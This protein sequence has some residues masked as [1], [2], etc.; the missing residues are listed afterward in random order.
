MQ[1]VPPAFSKPKSRGATINAPTV[2]DLT[3]LPSEGGASA[4]RI[5]IVTGEIAG[6][7]YNGGIGTANRG[8]ALSLQSAGFAV[9]VL[10]TRVESGR[11]FTFRGSF[12]EQVAAFRALGINLLCIDHKGRWDD[13]LGKSLRV[14]ETLQSRPYDIAFFDDT[15][16]N[17]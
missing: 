16:G 13:W 15:H 5:C 17:A 9:D 2:L 11:P 1:A 4:G 12:E 3:R 7:D 14:M 6:P 8:L 10:Y